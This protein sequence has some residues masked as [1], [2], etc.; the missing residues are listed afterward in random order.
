MREKGCFFWKQ[1]WYSIC[2]AHLEY[3]KDCPRCQ[4]G[5]WKSVVVGA[6]E[7]FVYKYSYK[8]WFYWMNGYFP[9]HDYKHNKE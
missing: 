4:T 7:H 8:H 9:D 2:S 5:Y 3:D 1:R 6:I